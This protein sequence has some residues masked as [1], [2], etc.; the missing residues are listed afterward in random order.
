M[1]G[2][3]GKNPS[4]SYLEEFQA[5]IILLQEVYEFPEGIE[6][7]YAVEYRK[8]VGRTGKEQHFGTALLVK[9]EILAEMPLSSELDWVNLELNHFRNN[10]ISYEVQPT[11]LEPANVISVYSPYWFIDTERLQ[12]IDVSGVKLD[13]NPNIYLT[14]ILW[15]ALKN[16]QPK[17]NERWIVGG[18]LN[19][20]ETF[21]IKWEPRGN[22]QI[23]DRM[24]DLGFFECLKGYQRQLTPTF[25]HSSGN[26]ED[27]IDHLFVTNC[28]ATKLTE[29]KTGDH[30]RVFDN[31]LSDHLPIVAD[32]KT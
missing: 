8:A 15:C 29:C 18:D 10:L 11:G 2:A 3:N 31:S 12:G 22:H 21:D 32:F 20:S 26:F 16:A 24:Q 19:S 28:L 1:K 25:K 17:D 6:D 9:G 5:D 14:E 4:W 13:D 27:Q 7:R 23:M 30:S